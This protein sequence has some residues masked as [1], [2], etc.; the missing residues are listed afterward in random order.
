MLKKHFF[1]DFRF[2][3]N[4]IFTNYTA[5]SGLITIRDT[6]LFY[7]TSP[8]NTVIKFKKF[9]SHDLQQNSGYA[10]FVRLNLKIHIVVSASF[11]K[12]N[13]GQRKLIESLWSPPLQSS[14]YPS[15][16]AS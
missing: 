7:V 2:I 13:L 16:V 4:I 9:I 12:Q 14:L 8:R 5:N 11:M 15:Q 6:T 10:E 1:L 3:A